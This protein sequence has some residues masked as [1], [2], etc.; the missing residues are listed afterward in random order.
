[1]I[2]DKNQRGGDSVDLLS[3]YVGMRQCLYE[4]AFECINNK[5]INNKY[6]LYM[7][8][9]QMPVTGARWPRHLRAYILS[10]PN[11]IIIL[12]LYLSWKNQL[13][14]QRQISHSNIGDNFSRLHII[15]LLFH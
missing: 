7:I 8:C 3:L 15:C 6:K 12:Q 14:E 2:H 11:Y 4:F 13:Q 5:Y 1:M 10:I 9:S